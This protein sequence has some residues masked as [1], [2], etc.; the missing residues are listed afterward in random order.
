MNGTQIHLM[1]S[2]PSCYLN[3]VRQQLETASLP[4]KTDDFF[5]YCNNRGSM[6]TGFYS[7]RPTLK[8]LIQKVASMLQVINLKFMYGNKL[9]TYFLCYLQ[10]VENL[11]SAV[12]TVISRNLLTH[13]RNVTFS[14]FLTVLVL[15][16]IMLQAKIFSLLCITMQL[17]NY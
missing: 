1:Y 17:R 8:G 5:P 10:T 15:I 13:M 9:F 16:K 2:T 7:S 12:T 3:A 14:S 11:E 4:E 6:W